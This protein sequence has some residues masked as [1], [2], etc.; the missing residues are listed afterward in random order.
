MLI[1]TQRRIWLCVGME[2]G[3]GWGRGEEKSKKWEWEMNV[4]V[5]L[6]SQKPMHNENLIV[7]I[8]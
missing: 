1:V 8:K 2:V 4:H 6:E 7:K 3:F 5:D